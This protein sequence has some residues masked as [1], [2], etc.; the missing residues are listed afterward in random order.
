VFFF[1]K[2]QWWAIIPA[3]I[4]TTL[5]LI[6]PFAASAEGNT[7]TGQLVAF[8]MFMGFAVPFAWLW[9]Q[10]GIY[11]TAWAKYP[12]VGFVAAAVITLALGRVL[13]SGWPILLI[14]IG[15]WLLY[16]SF[17]QPKLKS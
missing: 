3:G 10:R 14:V 4:L 13:E 9:L 2:G 17:H 16:D 8:V 11:P 6:I 5:A 12:A 1:T 15:A 7:F